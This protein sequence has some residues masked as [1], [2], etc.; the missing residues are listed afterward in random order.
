MKANLKKE[1]DGHMVGNMPDEVM[2]TVDDVNEFM[3]I[4]SKK[5]KKSIKYN[6]DL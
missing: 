3:N 1:E 6:K 2:K 4:L 5:N